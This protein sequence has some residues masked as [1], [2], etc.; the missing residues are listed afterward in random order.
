[1]KKTALV[2]MCI[3]V[4]ALSGC[5]NFQ[6]FP[7]SDT[8]GGG[9]TPVPPPPGQAV[10]DVQA[11]TVTTFNPYT[12]VFGT[13]TSST[14]TTSI[15]V[16]GDV[17]SMYSINGGTPTATAGTVKTNDVVTVQNT[18]SNLGSN[19]TISTLLNVGGVGA[20][21]NSTTGTLIFLTKKSAPLSTTYPSDTA[22][23]PST[24][25]GSFVFPATITLDA[26]KTTALNSTIWI[27]GGQV[28]PGATITTGQTLQLRHTT[29]ATS[30]AT[31]VTAVTLTPTTSGTPYTVTYKS[32]TQ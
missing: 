28:A 11:D 12:V 26:A 23:V 25:P 31:A 21:Y 14:T 6:W 22:T 4:G 17:S 2:V 10:T 13:I 24:L 7:S 15:S 32:V 8:A 9:T 27:S 19:L 30:G 29:A 16:S 3:V 18:S 1:M 5:G 20:Y